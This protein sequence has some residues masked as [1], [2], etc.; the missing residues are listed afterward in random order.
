MQLVFVQTCYVMIQDPAN[1]QRQQRAKKFKMDKM[2]RLK[3]LKN[4]YL[5]W[6]QGLTNTVRAFMT[7]KNR[8]LSMLTYKKI[9]CDL[10]M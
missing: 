9:S 3:T 1:T 6:T 7:Y 4:T 2:L 10:F 5:A 8:G